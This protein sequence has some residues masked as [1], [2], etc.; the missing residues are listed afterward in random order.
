M[1]ITFLQ[2]G[3][4]EDDYLKEG[5]AVFEDRIRHFL[6][7]RSEVLPALKNAGNLP[8]EQ[9]KAKEWE[10]MGRWVEKADCLVLLDE[11]GSAFTSKEF[12]RFLQDRMNAGVR[13]L[14]FAV[15]GPYGFAP[16]A[17]QSA[18]Y[19]VSLSK[20][21]FS[22]QMVRLFF[23]EQVYRALTILKGMPYHNE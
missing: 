14:M 17:Y 15:G 2:N 12:A 3:K 9:Q 21:T 18:R 19:K 13:N 20:M 10:Q 1:Q 8:V 22:H 16:Q 23:V 6:P 5:I 11:H 4:T 7:Y